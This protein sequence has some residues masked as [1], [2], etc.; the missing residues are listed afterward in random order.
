MRRI[1]ILLAFS[2]LSLGCNN[3]VVNNEMDQVLATLWENY[4]ETDFDNAFVYML[5]VGSSQDYYLYATVLEDGAGTD[6]FDERTLG[7]TVYNNTIILIQN[8]TD[9]PSLPFLF[10]NKKQIKKTDYPG[11]FDEKYPPRIVD[12]YYYCYH[13]QEDTLLFLYT[14]PTIDWSNSYYTYPQ[15]LPPEIT[16]MLLPLRPS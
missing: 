4:K 13:V 14:T 15:V 2:I 7:Y 9:H 1:I 6:S 5:F 10:F 16:G 11:V 3:P 8:Y 12:P